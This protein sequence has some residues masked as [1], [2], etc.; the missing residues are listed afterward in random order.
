[1]TTHVHTDVRACAPAFVDAI[2]AMC[3]SHVRRNASK[4][5]RLDDPAN[6][7]LLLEMID[8]LHVCRTPEQFDQIGIKCALIISEE[9]HDLPLHA[10]FNNIVLTVHKNF[11]YNSTG[12]PGVLAS[13][14]VSEAWNRKTKDTWF[15]GMKCTSA[16]LLSTCI[17]ELLHGDGSELGGHVPFTRQPLKRMPR[18]IQDAQKLLLPKNAQYH[19]LQ[20]EDERT[21]LFVSCPYEEAIG[22]RQKGRQKKRVNGVDDT[23]L[24]SQCY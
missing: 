18:H 9:W 19:M 12:V 21:V 23:L 24:C 15:S 22:R 7:P 11:S 5:D 1:M 2:L 17:K 20:E 14:N 13:N 6:L 8:I 4:K 10:W 16:D 3:Y